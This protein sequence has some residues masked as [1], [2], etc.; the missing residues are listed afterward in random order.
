MRKY[1]YFIV[2]L[3]VAL[4]LALFGPMTKVFPFF[5]LTLAVG[6]I[7]WTIH[8]FKLLFKEYGLYKYYTTEGDRKRAELAKDPSRFHLS[9]LYIMADMLR[10]DSNEVQYDKLTIMVHYILEVIPIEYRDEAIDTLDFLTCREKGSG[11]HK[12]TYSVLNKEG[13]KNNKENLF[14][15]H[16]TGG[17]YSNNISGW[18]MAEELALY[19]SEADRLYIMYLLFR[20]AIADKKLTLKSA[21]G[22]SRPERVALQEL[23]V[24]GLKI[25]FTTLKG[26]FTEWKAGRID[27]WYQTNIACRGNYP[28]STVIAD[29][30]RHTKQTNFFSM[31]KE[32]LPT[33]ILDDVQKLLCAEFFS[34]A[35]LVIAYITS[36][37]S[38][39]CS[40]P[41]SKVV[42]GLV[43]I[44]VVCLI[45]DSLMSRIPHSS[46]LGVLRTKAE[47]SIQR[48]SLILNSIT[49]TLLSLLCWISAMNICFIQGNNTFYKGLVSKPSRVT[50]T[51]YSHSRK[52]GDTYYIDFEPVYVGDINVNEYTAREVSAPTKL[53]LDVIPYLTCHNFV[54][55]LSNDE[56]RE[57][58]SVSYSDYQE[59]GTSPM[60]VWLNFKVGYYN[61][62]DFDGFSLSLIETEKESSESEE[63]DI[64]Y[65]GKDT[66]PQ[67]AHP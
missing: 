55:R 12:T 50:G 7:V 39:M 62:I 52:H 44:S 16:K 51:H 40:F 28:A 45:L 61:L 20:L 26:L 67:D 31:E 36:A 38:L 35:F 41:Q 65:Y 48:K 53:L 13:I 64:E 54:G 43:V 25:P 60:K 33:S 24:K 14:F 27:N 56:S 3:A 34:T 63:S 5:F 32:V 18:R 37:V 57:S 2:P 22:G 17:D 59:A 10:T 8:I 21:D 15:S 58:V 9:V 6:V 11:K 66:I 23:C 19:I 4:F 29:L 1:L 42:I 49:A 46:I 47:S 30:F